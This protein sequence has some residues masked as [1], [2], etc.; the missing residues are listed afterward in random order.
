MVRRRARAAP[1]AAMLIGLGLVAAPTI[2]AWRPLLIW[3]SS[4][5]VPLGLYAAQPADRIEVGDLVLVRPPEA[6][7]NFLDQRAYV[8]REVPLLKHV[9]ALPPQTV[10]AAG[11][12]ITV[13][14]RTAAR[15]HQAD[16]RGRPLPAWEGCRALEPGQVFLLNAAARDSLDGRYFGSLP[17]ASIASRL[18]PIWLTAGR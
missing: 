8:A 4:A 15:R 9:A 11:D 5:S 1:A 3:N 18:R 14:G 13:D 10:C 7:A 12:T 6:L 17:R 16:R 2:G